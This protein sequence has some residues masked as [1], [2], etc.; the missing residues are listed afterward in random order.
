LLYKLLRRHRGFVRFYN[1]VMVDGLMGVN[2]Q[3]KQNWS[4]IW[5]EFF[6]E[7]Q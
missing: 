1:L 4:F 3:Q 7:P 6:G 2:S 5:M